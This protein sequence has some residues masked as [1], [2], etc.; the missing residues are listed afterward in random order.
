MRLIAKNRIPVTVLTGYLGSGK[1]TLLNRILTHKDRSRVIVNEFGAVG[2]DSKL[3]VQADEQILE[4]NNGC[5]CCT[6]RSDLIRI[7][8]DLMLWRGKFD[9]LL[10][11]TT[12][13]ADPGPVIQSFFTNGLVRSRTQLDA[14]IEM[15]LQHCLGGL[16]GLGPIELDRRVFAEPWE[17]RMFG[18]NL[19]LLGLSEHLRKAT[20]QYAIENVP[21]NF[22]SKYTA[23]DLRKRGEAMHPF[24]YFRYRYYEKWLA[25]VVNFLISEHYLLSSLF[26]M[27]MEQWNNSARGRS[28][29][30]T[31]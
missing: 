7:I 30:R 1:T 20:P 29:S 6:V 15:K 13:L 31:E 11:E 8:G 24:D 10:I 19:A 3:V 23:A 14:V 25:S 28:K 4:M 22:K 21:T 2:I 17:K 5:I 27:K 9:H 12:G 18:I 26:V 16:E